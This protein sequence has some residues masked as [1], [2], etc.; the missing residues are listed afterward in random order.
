MN[1]FYA[2]C[3]GRFDG[4]DIP[5]RFSDKFVSG[6]LPLDRSSFCSTLGSPSACQGLENLLT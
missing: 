6:P 4:V 2:A 1:V 5:G 3:S